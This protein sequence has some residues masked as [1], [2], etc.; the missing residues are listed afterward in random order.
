MNIRKHESTFRTPR[1]QE[2]RCNAFT[3]CTSHPGYKGT[4]VLG[5]PGFPIKAHR[6]VKTIY[7]NE[8]FRVLVNVKCWS[9]ALRKISVLA[10]TKKHV[11][12]FVKTLE[13]GILKVTT[14]MYS[15]RRE[16]SLVQWLKEL[17]LCG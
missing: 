1:L 9:I 7:E 2:R 14:H 13:K 10:N 4:V 15:N 17:I 6:Y 3:C 8:K 16:C 11:A 12:D 5:H